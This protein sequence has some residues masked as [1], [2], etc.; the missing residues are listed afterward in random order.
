MSDTGSVGRADVK[1]KWR[2]RFEFFDTHGSPATRE[3]QAAFRQLPFGKRVLWGFNILAF[4]F[5]PIYYVVLG[6]WRKAL[7][8]LAVGFGVSVVLILVEVAMGS[9]LPDFVWRVLPFFCGALY[10]T[11]ANYSYYLHVMHG[12]RSWNP[13]EGIFHVK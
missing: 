1:P 8:L 13:V 10:A 12:N 3:Y 6:M 7:V 11:C 2:E 4:L 9:P 5:G